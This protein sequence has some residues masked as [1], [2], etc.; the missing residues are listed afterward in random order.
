LPVLFI[1]HGSPMMALA[2]DA[3]AVFLKALG[4]HLPQPRGVLC[5]SAHW[6]SD[7]PRAGASERPATIHDFYGFPEPL[8][9]IEYPAPGSPSLADRVSE[10]SGGTTD[11]DR[12]LDHGA[13]MPL[14]FMYPAADV[15]VVQLSVQPGRDAAYHLA[16]G[17][18]LAPLRD[19]GILILA[20]GGLTHNLAEFRRH[21]AN[22]PPEGYAVEF[23]TWA[24]EVV[25][26][27]DMDA[28]ARALE[29]PHYARSHPTPEHFLPLPVA[30]GAA[31][32]GPG[33]IIHSG[34]T[35]GVLSMRAFV[36]E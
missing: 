15:P 35:H 21:A 13:W 24:T 23:E 32:G 8:Y 33:R 14:R 36:F 25:E 5:V 22:D 16:L 9:E 30:M 27:G 3:T 6:E 29:A 18:A 20:S 7:A 28:M 31:G 17:R 1:S 19:D 2:P 10:L 12:G 26:A 34:W 4:R 11:P